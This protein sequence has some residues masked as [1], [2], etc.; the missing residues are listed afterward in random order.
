MKTTNNEDESENVVKAIIGD[1][2]VNQHPKE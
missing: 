1:S 2:K